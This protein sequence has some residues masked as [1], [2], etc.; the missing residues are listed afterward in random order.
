MGLLIHQKS[1]ILNS[2]LRTGIWPQFDDDRK[3]IAFI[4]ILRCKF[5]SEY[6]LMYGWRIF[7]E[8]CLQITWKRSQLN[9]ECVLRGFWHTNTSRLHPYQKATISVWFGMCLHCSR[10]FVYFCFFFCSKKNN[11]ES[12]IVRY[13]W[14][15]VSNRWLIL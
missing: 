4:Y 10:V 6:I 14:S 5:V 2:S 13:K 7:N 3:C 12:K 8:K 9:D 11:G 15:N 1:N